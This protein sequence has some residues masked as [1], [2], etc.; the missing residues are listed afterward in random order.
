MNMSICLYLHGLRPLQIAIIAL[1]GNTKEKM[2]MFRG[3]FGRVVQRLKPDDMSAQQGETQWK[4]LPVSIF[5]GRPLSTTHCPKQ[6]F[7]FP[8]VSLRCGNGLL[9]CGGATQSYTIMRR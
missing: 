1:S 3:L 9:W 7:Y 8:C 6:L 5:T 2:V 4:G